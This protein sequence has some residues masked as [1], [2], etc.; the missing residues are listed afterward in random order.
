MGPDR[1]SSKEERHDEGD[2]AGPQ[3]VGEN[4]GASEATEK[5]RE[6]QEL[7]EQAL[8]ALRSMP[9]LNH[10]DSNTPAEGPDLKQPEPEKGM[11]PFPLLICLALRHSLL[12]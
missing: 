11:V 5:V 7:R 6:A 10:N 3:L 8:E 9:S 2:R 12:L 1:R 4:S